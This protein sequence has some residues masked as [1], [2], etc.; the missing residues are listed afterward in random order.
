MLVSVGAAVIIPLS[1]D[2]KDEEFVDIKRAMFQVVSGIGFIGT[3]V[4]YIEEPL[5]QLFAEALTGRIFFLI[6]KPVTKQWP[7]FPTAE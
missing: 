7:S 4:I 6:S 2:F 5:H 3:G 1:M